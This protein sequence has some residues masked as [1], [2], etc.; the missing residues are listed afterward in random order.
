[1]IR[2]GSLEID[3]N[4]WTA[5][6][7]SQHEIKLANDQRDVLV[8]TRY[9]PVSQPV[10]PLDQRRALASRQ[11]ARID[12]GLVSL[13]DVE[14]AGVIAEQVVVKFFENRGTPYD[15]PTITFMGRLTLPLATRAYRM[16]IVCREQGATGRRE[17]MIMLA[18]REAGE[19]RV[20]FGEQGGEFI[21][22]AADPYDSSIESKMLRYRSD[23]AN[24]DPQ[25]PDHPLSRL[26]SS[27]R[28]VAAATRL[29]Q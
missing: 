15:R 21:D 20:E 6:S 12:Y 14:V 8:V 27:L 5:Y 19:V 4:G 7:S 23:D 11:L 16:E 17:A 24:Y 28:E 29:G 10:P 9:S 1:M 13:D 2:T 25:F 22:W 3:A 26:R 18:L